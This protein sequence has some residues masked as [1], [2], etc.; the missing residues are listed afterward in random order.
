MAWAGCNTGFGLGLGGIELLFIPIAFWM[1]DPIGTILVFLPIILIPLM[2]Y[3]YDYMHTYEGG[4]ENPTEEEI[5]KIQSEY[6][7]GE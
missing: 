7:V 5:L 2:V 4:F 3:L 1:V 6:V